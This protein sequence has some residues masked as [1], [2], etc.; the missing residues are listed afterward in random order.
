MRNKIKNYLI[1]TGIPI[2]YAI[3]VRLLF[4]LELNTWNDFFA[5]MSMTFLFLLPT[6]IGALTVYLSSQE[7]VQSIAY[8][9]LG[10]RGSIFSFL[11]ITLVLP[12]EGSACW[13][14]ILPEFLV[15]ASIGAT[16]GGDLK[17]Q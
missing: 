1:A 9:I 16:F 15:T 13:L 8:R 3:V 17:N 5:V 6:I 12:I 7:K 14:M 10:P 4:G 2:V 11:L